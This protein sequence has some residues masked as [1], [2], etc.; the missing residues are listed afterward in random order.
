MLP[1]WRKAV[2]VIGGHEDVARFVRR[3]AKRLGA[4]LDARDGYHQL[5]VT[6]LPRPL[7]ERLDAIGFT[8]S[9]K[10]AFRHPT[11]AGASYIHRSHPLVA[12]LADHVVEQTLDVDEPEIGARTGAVFTKDVGIRT[13]LYL[14]RL[15]SQLLV[16]RRG[17]D[18]RY[19]PLK[20]LLAEECL[21]LAIRAGETPEILTDD[22]ALALLS[23]EPCRNMTN[24][25]KSHIIRQALQTL[26]DMKDVFERVAHER[27]RRLLADHRR[28]RE[29]SDA[30]G[31][32]HN[33]VPALPPDKIGIYVF[34]PMASF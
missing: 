3:S 30:K 10:I 24:G 20:S 28:I 14:L 15:R 29:A 4:P 18:R 5:P 6:H 12:T 8:A 7:Q 19:S 34:L 17:P 16:E 9:A 31:L 25:Q 1:E 33:V 21:A 23:L 32:R 22:D 27:A 11:P 2:S 13:V 26:P